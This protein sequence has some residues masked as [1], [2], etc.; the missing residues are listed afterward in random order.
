MLHWKVLPVFPNY[1]EEKAKPMFFSPSTSFLSM[2]SL[3]LSVFPSVF[4]ASHLDSAEV[5]SLP[6]CNIFLLNSSKIGLQLIEECTQKKLNIYE[7]I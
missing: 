1:S 4:H 2:A 6:I 5:Y 3:T 7:H